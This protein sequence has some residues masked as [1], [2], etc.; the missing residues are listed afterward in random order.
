MTPHFLPTGDRLKPHEQWLL[1]PCSLLIKWGY[2]LQH[3]GFAN[4]PWTGK[5]YKTT[6]I[7][8]NVA[9]LTATAHVKILHPSFNPA[10]GGGFSEVWWSA[11]RIWTRLQRAAG[12]TIAE[13]KAKD[14]SWGKHFHLLPGK[15]T[16][17]IYICIYIYMYICIYVYMYICIYVYMYIC[18]Y[19]Y[20]YICI[21][22]Y[23]YICIYVYMYVC[24]Y[25]CM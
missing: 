14:Q 6:S 8:W 3:F 21:Y 2:P 10:V 25:V 7:S 16:Q 24:M 15:E 23:M 13:A 11:G 1:N 17:Y 20:M 5:P 22:V 9:G 4:N 18:I 12:G 19:V